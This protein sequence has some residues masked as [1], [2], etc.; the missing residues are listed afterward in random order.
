MIIN[1]ILTCHRAHWI[2]VH[3]VAILEGYNFLSILFMLILSLSLSLTPTHTYTHPPTHTHTHTPTHPHTHTPAHRLPLL[4]P[5]Y[6]HSMHNSP[7]KSVELRSDVSREL[8]QTLSQVGRVQQ[9]AVYRARAKVGLSV[10]TSA[11]TQRKSSVHFPLKTE[12]F[13]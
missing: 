9:E 11:C 6:L 8:L 13:K 10:C 3:V 7:V 12:R 5:P 4:K 2:L 1:F